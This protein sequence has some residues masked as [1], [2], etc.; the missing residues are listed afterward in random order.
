MTMPSQRQQTGPETQAKELYNDGIRDARKADRLQ[1]SAQELTDARKQER[2][3]KEAQELYASALGRFQQAVQL[4]PRM[5]EAWNY[6]G[7]TNRKLGHYDVALSAYERTLTLQPGYSEAI[8]YRGE[9]YL[10]LNRIAD[11]QQAY[12]D[13]FAANRGLAAKLLMAMKTWIDTQRA[14]PGSDPAVV[15]EFGKW[16]QERS[17]IA[18]QTASLTREGTAATW[19]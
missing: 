4:N 16:V 8:E 5:Y 17:Q 10:A 15:S 1:T 11:A 3:L 9:A 13:L 18:G 19:Q 14:T 12:L 2:T 6:V 7:Y